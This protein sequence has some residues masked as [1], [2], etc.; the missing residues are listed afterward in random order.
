M[1]S[2]LVIAMLAVGFVANA[3]T[4]N[5]EV[6]FSTNVADHVSVQINKSGQAAKEFDEK[7]E[8][9]GK[10][11]GLGTQLIVSKFSPTEND[12][13]ELKLSAIK[14]SLSRWDQLPD[15]SKTPFFSVRSINDTTLSVV[16]GKWVVMD[17]INGKNQ[18]RIRITKNK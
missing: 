4:Y 18:I 3:E 12:E 2:L 11:I 14:R 6:Q 9:E 5:V 16:C 1:R 8:F 7:I 15:G 13:I 17:G 10:E